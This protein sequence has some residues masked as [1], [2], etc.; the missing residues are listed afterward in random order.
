MLIKQSLHEH[1]HISLS[2]FL[3]LWCLEQSE[4]DHY[5][6]IVC[7]TVISYYLYPSIYLG[8]TG[9]SLWCRCRSRSEIFRHLPSVKQQ[10]QRTV[11]VFPLWAHIL[12]KLLSLLSSHAGSL[13]HSYFLFLVSTSW[14]LK[15]SNKF[16]WQER[17]F[18]QNIIRNWNSD[19]LHS[20][21]N[22]CG[23]INQLCPFNCTSLGIWHVCDINVITNIQ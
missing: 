4:L 1:Y 15:I 6:I 3:S 14:I 23:F 11:E 10:D 9:L 18:D 19:H 8:T 16:K 17:H 12:I 7:L 5:L 22:T 21:T 20:V 2:L 13:N